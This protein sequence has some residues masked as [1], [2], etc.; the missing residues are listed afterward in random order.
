VVKY[1]LIVAIAVRY[2]GSGAG[3]IAVALLVGLSV[4]AV[5]VLLSRTVRNLAANTLSDSAGSPSKS[6]S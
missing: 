1:D 2:L 3:E 4:V 5:F 6:P